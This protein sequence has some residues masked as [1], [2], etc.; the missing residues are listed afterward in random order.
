MRYLAAR[1]PKNSRPI[2][3][4]PMREN[5]DCL[6]CVVAMALSIT[7][8][9][10]CDGLGGNLNPNSLEREE[11]KRRGI[12]LCRLM[13]QNRCGVLHL[14]DV[15]QTVLGRRYWVGMYIDDPINPLSLKITHS[16]VVDEAGR[17]FDPN[18]Q[19]GVFES[20][21]DW[22]AAMTLTHRLSFVS[23]FFDFTL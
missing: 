7:Y 2:T 18:P 1:N 16:I 5:Y 13:E 6:T 12:A 19:Y 21:S 17:T 22:S 3:Y 15:T 11:T 23:E 4:V 8:E 20:L 10:A 9:Q 14:V